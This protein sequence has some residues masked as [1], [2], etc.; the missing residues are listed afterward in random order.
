MAERSIP[1]NVPHVPY[2][3]H[4]VPEALADADYFDHAARSIAGGYAV[5]GY[6][7]THAVI[8]L[9]HNAATALRASHQPS[10][11]DHTD[12]SEA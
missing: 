6:N 5:G 12:G 4:G 9:L 2:G 7:V 3:P 11:P 1:V 8:E 10:E